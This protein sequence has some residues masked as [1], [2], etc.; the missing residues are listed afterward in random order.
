M[1]QRALEEIERQTG[2]KSVLLVGG[3]TPADN[4]DVS[5]HV[6]DSSSHFPPAYSRDCRYTS[7]AT[8]T[9]RLSFTES[10]KGFAECHD[11]FIEW[12]QICYCKRSS[13]TT[14]ALLTFIADEERDRR[15]GYSKGLLSETGSTPA[16]RLAS[17]EPTSPDQS[18]LNTPTPQ[19]AHDIEGT[20]NPTTTPP[21]VLQTLGADPYLPGRYIVSFLRVFKQFACNI[22][23]G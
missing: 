22:P 5:T 2:F 11:A 10:W 21:L 14:I 13:S 8:A 19:T 3:L 17:L 18:T 9:T 23:R 1:A 4:G 12:V 16:H 15:K 6:Y 7:G 20:S